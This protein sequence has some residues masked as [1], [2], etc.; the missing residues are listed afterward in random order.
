MDVRTRFSKPAALVT[1]CAEARAYPVESAWESALPAACRPPSRYSAEQCIIG[2]SFILQNRVFNYRRKTTDTN[3]TA[4]RPKTTESTARPTR[5]TARS[6][7]SAT[8]LAQSLSMGITKAESRTL[9]DAAHQ[10]KGRLCRMRVGAQPRSP[11]RAPPP[12]TRAAYR[13]AIHV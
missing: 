8:T 3:S 7:T 5:A 9:I 6:R 13:L 12:K 4:A 11:K 10:T 1:P 2:R